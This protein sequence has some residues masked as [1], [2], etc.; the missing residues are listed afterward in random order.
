MRDWV[1]YVRERL[2]LPDLTRDREARIV[3]EL[4]SQLEDFYR[5]AM[6]GG[7]TDAEADAHARRQIQDW[8]ALAREVARADRVH[9]RPRI[10]R[11]AGHIEDM[12][13][14]RRGGL[15]MFAE[16]VSDT[17]FAIRQLVK[18]PGFALVAIIT[19]AL[20]TG[21]TS[22][23]FSV[24]NGVLLRPLPY[25]EPDRLVRVIEILPRFGRFAVAPATYLDWRAQTT[26]LERT[27]A[28]NPGSATLITT[29]G[30]ERVIN[31]T[32]SWDF[33]QLLR[34]TPM[35]GGTF[36]VEHDVPGKTDVVVLSHAMWQQRFGGDRSI[37]GRAIT[38]NGT[39]MTVLGVMPAGFQMPRDA[40]YWTPLAFDPAKA[41]RGGH[42]L[43]VFA[44][45]KPGV[46]LEQANAELKTISERLAQ[47]YPESSA[48]ESAEVV[49]LLD[50][51]VGDIREPLLTLLAAVAVVVLIACANVANLLLVRASVREK[52]FAIR[53]AL[54]AGRGRLVRQLLCESLVLALAGGAIGVVLAYGAIP[55][56]QRLNAGSIPRVQDV[57]IDT[58]VLLF[59]LGVSILTGLAFG[60]VPAWQ[61]SRGGVSAALKEGGRSSVGGG[62]WTR[63][64]LLVV[65]VALSI[66]LLVGAALLLRSFARVTNVDP[67]FRA[68]RVLA[69][70]V[71]LP[72]VSYRDRQA[73]FA[74]FD[75]LL[76]KLEALPQVRAA[77]V[78]QTLPMRGDYYLSFG[79]QG[80]PQ[81]KPGEGF[82]ASY[83]IAS[84][85]YFETLGIP[86][87]RGRVFTERDS[88]KAPLVAVIDESFVAKHF[89]GED[90]IGRGIGIGNGTDGFYEIVGIV[91][92]VRHG[93]LETKPTPT[94]YVPHRQDAFGSLWIMARTDADPAQLAP[95]AR[96]TVREIDPALPA[97]SIMP[98]PEVVAESV[99]QRRFSLLLLAAFAVIALVLASVGIYGVVA[100]SVSQRTQ[101]IGVRMAIGAE[102]SDVLRLVVGGGMKL[103][104]AGVVIGIA[105]AL[106]LS[107]YIA[108][109]L[110]ETER[111][112]PIS[113]AATIGTLLLV[114][115]AASFVP[116]RRAMNLDPVSAIRQ[117]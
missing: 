36:T 99:G 116:A 82:S 26:S 89:P 5:E 7:L 114:A 15:R 23:M 79:V 59:A 104:L 67:G 92:D 109:M 83:R 100:Y 17:R 51:I 77:A 88:D 86:L 6:A 84:P 65:E 43:A 41:S 63:N 87:K 66:V 47:Q 110:F 25:P 106:A 53:T 12:S 54:G 52:E 8:D 4:A 57:S 1:V 111:F 64:V 91:G 27:V 37:V 101:E 95:L 108:T 68:E 60:L 73:R 34:V 38:L 42:F 98:L 44:R 35:L 62:R 107:R 18:S 3:R 80:R 55:I 75:A 71:Q 40:E 58:T 30:P 49:P 19:I 102:R 32:V 31:A 13:G 74:F 117:E 113:Y 69:F 96:Q 97:F 14:D 11:M 94:M 103:A 76:A 46:T 56:I 72:Q 61:A 22:A 112:D 21:A 33:F 24:I 20:G 10:D 29:S 115:L 90:P 50:L 93:D 48:N 28:I 81:P 39:P 45:L 78:T 70:R 2:P 105:G 85:R 9:L 16:L